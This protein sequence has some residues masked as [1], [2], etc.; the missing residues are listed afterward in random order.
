MCMSIWM[1]FWVC[2]V[3]MCVCL[4]MF[5]YHILC[6]SYF[7]C[8]FLSN[9]AVE[10]SWVSVHFLMI[11]CAFIASPM[12][13]EAE[14]QLQKKMN[15]WI[16]FMKCT[17]VRTAYYAASNI[18]IVCIIST[19]FVHICFMAHSRTFQYNFKKKRENETN[20]VFQKSMSHCLCKRS[21]YLRYL[22]LFIFKLLKILFGNFKG[23]AAVE[24]VDKSTQTDGVTYSG[25]KFKRLLFGRHL[26][27]RTQ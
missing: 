5:D 20:N 10:I 16:Y 13:V 7:V 25:Q 17:N 9:S 6:Q 24:L 21:W 3:C 18:T 15:E 11:R 8:A 27:D 14:I 1:I 26:L 12:N 22:L 19:S 2:I 4:C 23:N